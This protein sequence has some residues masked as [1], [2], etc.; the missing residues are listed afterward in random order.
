ML[1]YFI[2]HKSHLDWTGCKYGIWNVAWKVAIAGLSA[3]RIFE[4]IPSISTNLMHI[5]SV[6]K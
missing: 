4:I 3:M 1:G 5:A 2:H 6:I